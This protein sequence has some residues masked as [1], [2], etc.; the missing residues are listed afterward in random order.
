MCESCRSQPGYHSFQHIADVSGQQYFYCFPAH[1][2]QSVRT[3]QDMLNF[4][5]HFPSEG[6]WNLLFHARGYGMSHMMPLP[7]ALELGRIVQEQHKM[8]LQK[9]YVIEG[10]WFMQF[11]LRCILP[12]LQKDMKEKFVSVQGSPLEIVTFLRLEG[13]SYKQLQCLRDKFE[14]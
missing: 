9:I 8:R 3:H 12:F 11:L 5:S 10:S 14:A 7:I 2:K 13:L 4:A 1:N 6:Q